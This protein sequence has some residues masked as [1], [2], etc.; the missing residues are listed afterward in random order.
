MSNRPKYTNGRTVYRWPAEVR[1]EAL[2]RYADGESTKAISSDLGPSASTIKNWAEGGGIRRSVAEARALRRF[3]EGTTVIDGGGYVRTVVSE[4]W[5]WREEMCLPPVRR[6][7]YVHRK[8]MA[9]SLGRPLRSD[10]QVH[11]ING[12]RADNRPENLQLRN[13]NHGSGQALRCRSCGSHDL[14]PYELS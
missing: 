8:V 6:W 9:E 7:V 5:P 11:H 14:E 10:E 12:D 3:E 1:Q 2:Q 13:G 4:D